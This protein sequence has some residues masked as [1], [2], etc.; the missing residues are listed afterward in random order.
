[1]F[2]KKVIILCDVF[3]VEI[4]NSKIKKNIQQKWKTTNRIVQSISTIT[5]FILHMR[6]NDQ[7]PKRLDQQIRA[8]ENK[9]VGDEFL[10]HVPGSGSR[11]VRN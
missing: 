10:L 9:E 5:Y 6:F 4:G 1:M 3:I 7:N 11:T 2:G 8:N